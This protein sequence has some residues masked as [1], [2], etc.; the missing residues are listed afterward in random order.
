MTVPGMLETRDGDDLWHPPTSRTVVVS[1]QEFITHELKE[2]LSVLCL[3]N[4]Y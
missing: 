3:R 1:T 4:M 2:L